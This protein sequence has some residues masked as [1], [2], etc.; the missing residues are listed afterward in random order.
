MKK[1][2]PINRNHIPDQNLF[3]IIVIKPTKKHVK[4]QTANTTIVIHKIIVNINL[5]LDIIDIL[6]FKFV[7]TFGI[8]FIRIFKINEAFYSKRI[9]EFY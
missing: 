2:R 4:K 8:Y 9:L 7:K 6:V 3:L 1:I 5:L